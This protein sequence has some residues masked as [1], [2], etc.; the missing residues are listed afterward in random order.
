MNYDDLLG[1]VQRRMASVCVVGLGYVGF[2]VLRAFSAAKYPTIGFDVN[3][4]RAAR[5]AA[6]TGIRCVSECPPAEVYIVCVPSPSNDH[7][8]DLSYLRAVAQV[9]PKDR[10]VVVESTVG[11]G[12]TEATFKGQA[13]LAFSP[14]REDP[15]TGRE[16]TTIPK[17]IAANTMESQMLVSSLYSRVFRSNLHMAPNIKTAE[18]SKLME[19]TYRAVNIALAC[20]FRDA[21]EVLDIDPRAATRAAST[22]PFGYQPFHAGVGVGGHCIAV[23]PWYL[24]DNVRRASRGREVPA[25]SMIRTAMAINDATPA[26]RAN[27]FAQMMRG[28][29]SHRAPNVLVLGVTYKKNIDD[30]RNSPAVAFINELVKKDYSI[31]WHDK[32]A[33]DDF[34]IPATSVCVAFQ[35]GGLLNYDAIVLAVDHDDFDYSLL[36]EHPCVYDM[37]GRLKKV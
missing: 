36:S 2:P 26:N 16:L 27:K 22:K 13:Y 32:N 33:P 5:V 11:P 1:R 37:C 28:E 6:E 17:V 25:L 20:D 3:P 4:A 8:P 24:V 12:D 19:N 34:K 31:S 35:K 23:D 18:M 14:E 10:L 9:V 15:G 7:K 21:C 29:V 30:V